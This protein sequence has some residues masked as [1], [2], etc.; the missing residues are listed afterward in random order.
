MSCVMCGGNMVAA[1]RPKALERDWWLAVVR[2]VPVLVWQ[3][4]RGVPR[5]RRWPGSWTWCSGVSWTASSTRAS[6]TSTRPWHSDSQRKSPRERQDD[7]D[8][9]RGR[10]GHSALMDIRGSAIPVD[11]CGRCCHSVSLGRR[12]TTRR[13]ADVQ[14]TSR[15]SRQGRQPQT[16]RVLEPARAPGRSSSRSSV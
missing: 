16:G 12:L 5:R 4:R 2:D 3:L 9:T 15:G 8:T 11:P 6:G 1:T 13:S 10:Q 7:I 14:R